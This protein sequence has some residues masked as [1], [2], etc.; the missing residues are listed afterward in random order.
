MVAQVLE[1][2]GLFLGDSRDPV[3]VEDTEILRAL[4]QSDMEVLQRIISDRNQRFANWGFKVPNLHYFLPAEERW[5][6]R[7][8]RYIIVFRDPLAIARRN[9][10]SMREDTVKALQDAGRSIMKLTEYACSLEAPTLL[11]SYEKALQCGEL[12]V[13]EVGSF[14]KLTPNEE[15][16]V[17]ALRAIA[18]NPFGYIWSTQLVY[19]GIKGT[20]DNIAGNILRG[21]CSYRDSADAVEIEVLVD[22]QRIGVFEAKDFR[23]DLRDAGIQLGNHAFN[24]DLS[25]FNIH[26]AS[27]ISVRP[28]GH[29]QQLRNSGETVEHLRA[30]PGRFSS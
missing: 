24:V 13:E 28:A 30:K 17:A 6:F 16:K 21:W 23:S 22:E 19:R 5:R 3:V 10:L 12:I 1:C 20:I 15:Q 8:P 7:N 27:V 2:L 11:I 18:P 25:R 14:C 26:P 9:E 4:Q 29:V